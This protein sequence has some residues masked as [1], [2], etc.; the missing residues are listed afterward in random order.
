MNPDGMSYLDLA[1][2]YS[3]GEYAH[4][5][6]SYWSPFYSWILGG[7]LVVIHPTSYW[8]FAV[9]HLTNFMIYAVALIAFTWMYREMMK[10]ICPE[11]NLQSRRIG[12][13]FGI[14]A[15]L[16]SSL[17]LITV[18]I[19]TPDMLVS[20]FV[21][22]TFAIVARLH[23]NSDSAIDWGALGVLI[24]FGYLAKAVM[25]PIGLLIVTA[26]MAS[27][28]AK[29][30]SSRTRKKTLVLTG[31]TL[32]I[33][34]A[35]A[36]PFVYGISAKAGRFTTGDSGKLAYMFDV[37]KMPFDSYE[38]SLS[39][40]RRVSLQHNIQPLDPRFASI[41]STVSNDG[42]T[43]SPWCSPALWYSDVRLMFEPKMQ[44]RAV[45]RNFAN[46]ARI[47]GTSGVALLLVTA[48]S[49]LVTLP[50]KQLTGASRRLVWCLI[51]PSVA[52][53]VMYTAI[54]VEERY[55]APFL[56]VTLSLPFICRLAEIDKYLHSDAIRSWLVLATTAC[57]LAVGGMEL[58]KYSYDY[59]KGEHLEWQAA[60]RLGA[61]GVMPGDAIA[62]IG[63]R[64]EY[65]YWAHLAHVKIA[66]HSTTADELCTASTEDR[67]HLMNAL[68]R[69]N[70]HFLV[71][72]PPCGI[73]YKQNCT[74]L[75]TQ[76]LWACRI[77]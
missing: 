6:N 70:I 31:M 72:E 52:A 67:I 7:M 66:A 50:V 75:G 12:E 40:Y 16:V 29:S 13:L 55:V 24:A 23:R 39:R 56:V 17:S 54:Y 2:Q 27:Q 74:P 11:T 37:N 20:V 60:Q 9:V 19:V 58:Y 21:Y 57:F 38:A 64:A 62:Q 65:S 46:W 47:A 73:S 30:E 36:G 49:V 4:A 18:G 53:L 26:T 33:A 25:L 35:I 45:V 43:Y 48:I 71:G 34:V 61:I 3:Q 5:V 44:L 32:C 41:V 76:G 14:S 69:A 22:C 59:G 51:L 15:F 63:G 1:Y 77:E 8:E 68:S 10:T 28:F 42:C